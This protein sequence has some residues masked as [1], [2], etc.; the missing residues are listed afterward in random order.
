[1]GFVLDTSFIEY[2]RNKCS[3][4][5]NVA[6]DGF[7]LPSSSSSVLA[8]AVEARLDLD[9][10][11]EPGPFLIAGSGCFLGVPVVVDVLALLALLLLDSLVSLTDFGAG[12][13]VVVVVVVACTEGFAEVVN[14]E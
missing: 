13:V 6:K 10:E 3:L 7:F 4:F 8:A 2:C 1:V 9:L 11:A 5:S 14:E 12:V